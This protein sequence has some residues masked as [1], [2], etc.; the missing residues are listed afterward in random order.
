MGECLAATG[1]TSAAHTLF[2]CLE[3]MFHP[4]LTNL[5]EALLII[6]AP[7]HSIKVLWD[8]RVI[9]IWQLKPVDWLV[10]I[11]AGVCSDGQADLCRVVSHLVYV[12]DVSNNN[13]RARHQVWRLWANR[14]LQWR[15]QHRLGSAA[16]K[17]RDL[18]WS[19]CCSHRN[20]A[21][22]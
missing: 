17:L 13:I 6:L 14:V 22:P 5:F 10:A 4:R 7:A 20:R 9:R 3:G 16:S 1:I 19:H 2:Q 21:D 8:D 15:H 12:F 11:V 18:N